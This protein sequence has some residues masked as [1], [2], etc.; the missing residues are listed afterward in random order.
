MRYRR[1]TSASILPR[2]AACFALRLPSLFLFCYSATCFSLPP[3]SIRRISPSDLEDLLRRLPAPYVTSLVLSPVGAARRQ[4]AR[5][6]LRL[7]T[8]AFFQFSR[9][10]KMKARSL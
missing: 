8:D 1:A 10:A 7:E 3:S 5:S 2:A 6:L 4:A 9:Y